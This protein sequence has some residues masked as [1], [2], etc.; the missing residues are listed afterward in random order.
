[1]LIREIMTSNPVTIDSACTLP[2][3]LDLMRANRIRRL[4]VLDA[5]RL[6]GIVTDRDLKE[7]SPSRATSLSVWEL[8]Y[9]LSKTKV[10][11]LM[12][13]PVVSVHPDESVERAAAL[14]YR[15]KIGGLPVLQDGEL[16]GIGPSCTIACLRRSTSLWREGLPYAVT[17]SRPG[18]LH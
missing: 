4:P 6:V 12:K 10:A 18:S 3:A 16:V 7:A 11:E 17:L 13:H 15:H 5:G 9:L 2:D 14:M 8:N 1:M